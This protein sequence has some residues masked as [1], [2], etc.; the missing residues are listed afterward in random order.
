M[1]H[2]VPPEH[3]RIV[4]ALLVTPRA[5]K[6]F[7]KKGLLAGLRLEVDELNW[8]YGSGPVVTGRAQPLIMALAGRT[9][10]LDELSGP[11]L[12]ELRGRM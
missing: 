7:I 5:S 1:T 6:A 3:A 10:T 4:L 12:D 11:G 9:A 2:Q 8:S